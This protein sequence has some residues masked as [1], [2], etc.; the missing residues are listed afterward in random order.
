MT[1]PTTPPEPADRTGY[2]WPEAGQSFS[3]LILR[4]DATAATVVDH[5]PVARWNLPNTTDPWLTWPQVLE[6]LAELEL[7]L[8]DAIQLTPGGA[9]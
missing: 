6:M 5:D 7:D 9:S 3:T 4:D 8:A 2:Y 1:E